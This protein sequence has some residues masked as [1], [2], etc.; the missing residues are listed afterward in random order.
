MIESRSRTGR[1]RSE[2][3]R[4]AILDAAL[5]LLR[6]GGY[7][8]L[9]TDAIAAEAGVGKQTIYRWWSSK[10]DVVLEALSELGRVVP[11]P[12]TGS[13]AGDLAQFL[14]STFRLLRGPKG[15]APVLKGLMA[16]AQVNPEFAPRFAAFIQSRREVLASIVRRG[17][18]A[19]PREAVEALVD[20]LYGA[21]WYRL[22]VG[23]ARLDGRAADEL[24][25]L[26]AASFGASRASESSAGSR[27]RHTSANDALAKFRMPSALR[28]LRRAD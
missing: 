12:D 11:V 28:R 17:G 10:A 22:L 3:S 6:E 9:T 21:M 19:A 18:E 13:L 23:H 16:E 14:A 4:E 24:A 26:A 5:T 15:S 25:E 2:A 8:A 7:G 20:M 27:A 1:K